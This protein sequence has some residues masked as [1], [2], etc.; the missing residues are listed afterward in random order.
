MIVCLVCSCACDCCGEEGGDGSRI[1][2]IRGSLVLIAIMMEVTAVI[3]GNLT[4]TL[5]VIPR[6]L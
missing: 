1:E 6:R 5:P 3:G 2:V 4:M